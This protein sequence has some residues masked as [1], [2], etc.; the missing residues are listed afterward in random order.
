MEKIYKS[1]K[2]YKRE[3]Q[4]PFIDSDELKARFWEG[5]KTFCEMCENN[6]NYYSIVLNELNLSVKNGEVTGKLLD[7]STSIEDKVILFFM[8]M[9]NGKWFP[10]DIEAILKY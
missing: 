3:E 8:D 5:E 6:H 1:C 4:N 7:T 2:Y 10:Y 9:W